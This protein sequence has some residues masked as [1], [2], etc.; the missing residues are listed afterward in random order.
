M[1]LQDIGTLLKDPHTTQPIQ[2]LGAQGNEAIRTIHNL[3]TQYLPPTNHEQ[4]RVSLPVAGARVPLQNKTNIEPP[5]TGRMN[6]R[7]QTRQ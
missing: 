4:P 3:L 6:T 7:S 5:T 1:A 2:D